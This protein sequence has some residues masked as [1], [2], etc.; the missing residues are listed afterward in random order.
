M[1]SVAAARR[2]LST[3]AGRLAQ[4]DAYRHTLRLP[5]TAFAQRAS[6]VKRE[7]L[8]RPATTTELYRWQRENL[9]V[10]ESG[11]FVLHDGPPYAN[12]GLHM[13]HALNKI[14]KDIM[15]RFQ[16]LC[17]RRV[18]YV[19]GWDCHGLPIEIK[20]QGELGQTAQTA[21]PSEIRQTARA[22]AAREV[23]RQREEFTQLA[24]MTDW[25]ADTTYRTMD[26]E[27][28][29]TQLRIFAKC[30]ER[31]LIYRQ[32]RPVYWSPSS[33][34]ALAEAEIE[35]DD[36]HTSRC[37]YIKAELHPNEALAKAV[38]S[39]VSLVVWTTTPWSL[40]GNMAIA[41]SE[42][43]DYSVVQTAHG[44]LLVATDLVES[45]TR[46]ATGRT[47]DAQG[48][49]GPAQEV[50]RVRGADLV[51]SQY[52]LCIA[53][54]LRDIVAAPFVTTASGTGLVHIAPAHG[55]EDYALWRDSGRLAERGLVSPIDDEGRF[56][57]SEGS[58]GGAATQVL[59]GME[60]LGDG[61]AAMVQLVDSL[62]GLL[63]EHAYQHSYPIDWRTKKPVLTRATSQWFADLSELGGDAQRALDNVKCIPAA[64]RARLQGLVGC[65]SEWC[66]SRQRAWGVPIPVVYD[67]ET[68]EPLVT[69]RNVE[70]IISTFAAHGTLDCWWTLDTEA[71][72]APEYRKEGRRWT[73]RTDTLDVW[74]DS[75]VSWQVLAQLL[76]HATPT[77]PVA[78]VYF[79]G[80]DQ[81][82][83]WFQ[84]SLL[85]RMAAEGPGA[86]APYA[87][88]VTHGFVV[89]S[90]GRKMSKSLGNVVVPATII[91][92]G[93]DYAPYGA[94]VLRWWVA[95]ADYTREI[96]VSALIIKHASDE[97]RKLRNTAR[98]MLGALSGSKRADVKP[99]DQVSLGLLDRFVLHELYLLEQAARTAYANH[100]FA[101]VTRRVLEFVTTTLSS[102][103]LD[104]VKDVLYAGAGSQREAAVSVID[105]LLERIT[106]MVAPVLPHLAEDINWYRDGAESDPKHADQVSSFFRRGW[107]PL[108]KRWKDDA[109]AA[110][111]AEL[112][113]LRA[114]VYALV[115]RCRE[116]GL[117][118]SEAQVDVEVLADDV[119]TAELAALCGVA[120]V[121]VTSCSMW[122][123]AS[124]DAAWERTSSNVRVRPARAE[125]CPRCW[126]H[127]RKATDELCERCDSIVSPKTF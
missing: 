70:H 25:S 112:L 88:L 4:K 13:G 20:A 95:K 94:D 124:A 33:G 86:A 54:E 119:H 43:A 97:V 17:G 12:G 107:T 56:V 48:V 125:K 28:E 117:V 113:R 83:G 105:T 73:R 127:T 103:Y 31:G 41:V 34:T 39:D 92:G 51:G 29:L 75:G 99:L 45:L 68:H 121:T 7:P 93:D 89:D 77:A 100:D 115:A 72:V 90:A 106:C 57:I 102:V 69:R 109:V 78:D 104:A 11:E 114:Q 27:Y 22:V 52:R 38:G 40:L 118:R 71:F 42:E 6:A 91:N 85:T 96:P 58:A 61:N 14:I 122:Q 126:R 21:S 5:Q 8:F 26:L 23:A 62:G 49:V 108:D 37:V 35:Y 87:T 82:R 84:S 55:Q 30:V 67:A 63:G 110:A 64:G 66:I 36:K 50:A 80:T 76:G 15:I 18:N 19:P 32:Y 10:G 3:S 24:I 53:D 65:R 59:A 46:V 16:V 47:D 116:D 111:A 2:C 98:F 79:E 120:S 60:A 101:Q 74:F 81:H 1:R 123:S 44:K 9:P